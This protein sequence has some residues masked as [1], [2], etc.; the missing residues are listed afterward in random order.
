[1]RRYEADPIEPLVANS[2]D[3]DLS[4]VGD[5]SLRLSV[6]LG[7]ATLSIR[8]LLALQSGSIIELGG[9]DKQPLDV[10]VNGRVVAKAEVVV[11]NDHY[12]VRIT[13]VVDA[14]D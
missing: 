8:K 9:E 3:R 5:V 10:C 2:E 13:E 6:E 11:V 12:G 4:F 14:A 1:M 7:R